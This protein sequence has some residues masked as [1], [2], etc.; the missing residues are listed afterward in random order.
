[1]GKFNLEV[2]TPDGRIFEGNVD[3]VSIKGIEGRMNILKDHTP[4]ISELSPGAIEF[5]ADGEMKVI[6]VSGGFIHVAPHKVIIIAFT[7]F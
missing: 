6:D 4:L 1:M 7:I 2:I 5:K 3:V